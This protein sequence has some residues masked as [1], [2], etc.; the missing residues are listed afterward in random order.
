MKSLIS[1]LCLFLAILMLILGFA[2]WS[3][4][5]PEPGI[6]LHR[7]RAAGDEDFQAVLEA[8]LQQRRLART[9]LL[10]CLFGG[11]AALV[12]AAFFT[13]RGSSTS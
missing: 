13:L 6:E 7:A 2:L 5:A 9:A 10:A 4:E 1:P 3:V 12:V 8:Q 11:S